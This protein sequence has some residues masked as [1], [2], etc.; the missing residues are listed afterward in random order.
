ML[1]AENLFTLNTDQSLE[2]L[3]IMDISVMVV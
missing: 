3:V 2:S 1:R